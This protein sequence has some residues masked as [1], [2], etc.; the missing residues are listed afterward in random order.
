MR[1]V[2]LSWGVDAGGEGSFGVIDG[3]TEVLTGAGVPSVAFRL[4]TLAA[5]SVGALHMTVMLT[6]A[7][8]AGLAGVDPFEREGLSRAALQVRRRLG[9][10]SD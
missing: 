8:G 3:L 4:P 6:A 1:E 2:E 5:N 10:P 9:A 7:F